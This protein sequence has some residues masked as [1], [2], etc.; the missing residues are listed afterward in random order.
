[1]GKEPAH[2]SPGHPAHY[3][4]N[5]GLTECL[6]LHALLLA[7]DSNPC[8]LISSEITK[9]FRLAELVGDSKLSIRGR[10]DLDNPR[11]PAATD[12]FGAGDS[13]P[14][15]QTKLFESANRGLGSCALPE[16][17]LSLASEI[18][19]TI[20][21]TTILTIS[22]VVKGCQELF[23]DGGR[24]RIRTAVR[25]LEGKHPVRVGRRA[26]G[27]P[28]ESRTHIHSSGSSSPVHLNDGNAGAP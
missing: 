10:S 17:P 7:W 27:I 2:H 19:E 14:L 13:D 4:D 23:L 5:K 3:Q 21:L 20:R 9:P 18:T 26:H 15:L 25:C 22:K 11:N 1:M 8:F 6:V 24:G 28:G 16:G 12:L